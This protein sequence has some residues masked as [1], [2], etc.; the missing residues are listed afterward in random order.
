MENCTIRMTAIL[1]PNIFHPVPCV[2]MKILMLLHSNLVFCLISGER[3][4]K[5][6]ESMV[7]GEAHYDSVS[8]QCH[9]SLVASDSAVYPT[10]LQHRRHQIFKVAFVSK[11]M[12]RKQ[13][14]DIY[15][16]LGK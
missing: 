12:P 13:R 4:S 2:S 3:S 5:A 10:P 9:T 1:T 8:G 16:G 14:I 7:L 6:H 15:V 11:E